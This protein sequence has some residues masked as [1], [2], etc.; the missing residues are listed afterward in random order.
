[1]KITLPALMLLLVML[2]FGWSMALSPR[3]SPF[4]F[5]PSPPSPIAPLVN[6][7]VVR[8]I[9]RT[10]KSLLWVM[11]FAE[12]RPRVVEA[13]RDEAVDTTAKLAGVKPDADV[14]AGRAQRID[15]SEGW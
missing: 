9:A 12:E 7:P 8:W 15:W 4:P 2:F 11:A 3:P 1:M 13:K 10:A 6:R 14:A 5:A